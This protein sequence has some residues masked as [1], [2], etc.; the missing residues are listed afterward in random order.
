MG[1]QSESNQSNARLA[2]PMNKEAQAINP[3]LFIRITKPVA[4]T[5][6]DARGNGVHTKGNK[7]TDP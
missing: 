6:D 3:M 7:Q 5:Q 2:M 4:H 1:V